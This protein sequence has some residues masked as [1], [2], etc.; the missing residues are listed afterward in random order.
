MAVTPYV[1]SFNPGAATTT[2]Y[3]NGIARVFASALG[4]HHWTIVGTPTSTTLTLRNNYDALFQVRFTVESTIVGYL[5]RDG[6]LTWTGGSKWSGNTSFSWATAP[7]SATLGYVVE[8]DDAITV[9]SGTG[10]TA[11]GSLLAY[12]LGLG[13]HIGRIF[14]PHNRNDGD[15]NIGE[16]GSFGGV[17]GVST[18]ATFQT[19]AWLHTTGYVATGGFVETQGLI[20]TGPLTWGL[21]CSPADANRIA[22][23]GQLPMLANIGDNG[24]IERLAPIPVSLWTAPSSSGVLGAHIGFTRYIR[25]RNVGIGGAIS[26]ETIVPSATDP[27]IAWRHSAS[28]GLILN[29]LHIWSQAAAIPVP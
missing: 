28:S 26:N 4:S 14:S 20:Q 5:S 19:N 16:Y 21:T 25:A 6:G 17:L 7:N 29:L 3:M 22:T 8:I 27:N 15:L 13:I 18:A 2:G 23:G 12:A 10:S 11:S 1:Y 9:V 24:D